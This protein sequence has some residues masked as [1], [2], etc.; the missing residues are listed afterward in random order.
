MTVDDQYLLENRAHLPEAL[1]VLL[2]DYPRESWEADPNFS[3]LI[4]FWLDRHIMFRRILGAVTA[5]C[6]AGL[7]GNI[8]TR[9]FAG[10][11]SKLGGMFVNQLHGHHMIEDTHYFPRLKGL[12]SRLERGFEILDRDHHALD[13]HLS[14]FADEANTCIRTAMAEDTATDVIAAMMA[15]VGRMNGFLDRHLVDE[16]ELIVPVLLKHAPADLT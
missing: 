14:D 6:E 2:E 12:E 4:R 8:E 11:L 16:E 10:K 9:V 1:R 5:D 15:A 7:D 13:K 3:A